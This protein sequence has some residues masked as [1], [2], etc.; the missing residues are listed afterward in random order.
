M[1]VFL[2]LGTQ[3]AMAATKPRLYCK[4]LKEGTVK[5]SYFFFDR[6][7]AGKL[8]ISII[9]RFRNYFTFTGRDGLRHSVKPIINLWKVCKRQSVL[10]TIA[11][12][13]PVC[14]WR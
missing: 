14:A 9:G 1:K 10:R 13:W 12:M 7:Y 8:S 2:Y 5:G 6:L 4:S 11:V 3:Y